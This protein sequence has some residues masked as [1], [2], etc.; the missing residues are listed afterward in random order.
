MHVVWMEHNSLR[1]RMI[2]E[3]MT[4][5]V[6]RGRREGRMLSGVSVLQLCGQHGCCMWAATASVMLCNL[7]SLGGWHWCLCWWVLETSC[8]DSSSK[9]KSDSILRKNQTQGTKT[10][11]PFKPWIR[12]C[13]CAPS[14]LMCAREWPCMHVHLTL[15]CTPLA[16]VGRWAEEDAAAITRYC[17][18][19]GVCLLGNALK[20]RV[21]CTE[22]RL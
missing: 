12:S 7:H 19:C 9:L 15:F 21:L 17:I 4:L 16:A 11:V 2:T 8:I 14:L 1:S 18:C 10:L 5:H 20:S 3:G 13:V 22:G 6:E